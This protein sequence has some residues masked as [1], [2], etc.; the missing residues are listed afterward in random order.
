MAFALQSN[1]YKR[2]L[3]NQ[4]HKNIKSP[5]NLILVK[6]MLKHL[7]IVVLLQ[8]I[9]DTTILVSMSNKG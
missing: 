1:Y 5:N 9:A 6:K 2:D 4:N 8:R 7:F 3:N